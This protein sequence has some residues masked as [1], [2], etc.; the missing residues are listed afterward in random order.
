MKIL[1][2]CAAG[3]TSS[4][5]VANMRKAVQEDPGLDYKIGSC[6]SN[7]TE[8][9]CPQ[10]DVIFIAPQLAYEEELLRKEYSDKKVILIPPVLYGNLDGK[11]VLGL[12]E[13]RE[14]KQ[15]QS[16]FMKL[17]MRMTAVISHSAILQSVSTAMMSLFPV[18]MLGSVFTLLLNF[19]NP[20]YLELVQ[21][22]AL[23]LILNL[24]V[25]M[26]TDMMA[27][28]AL[29]MTAYCYAEK[30]KCSQPGAVLIALVC[31]FLLIHEDNGV[32][33]TDYLGARGMFFSFLVSFL[34]VRFYAVLYRYVK[35]YAPDI[36]QLPENI[37]GSFLTILPML[38][39]IVLV[40]GAYV[41]FHRYVQV[42]FP[43]WFYIN[44]QESV[45]RFVGDHVF[46]AVAMSLIT[47]L[48]WF[49]GI[50]GGQITGTLTNPLTMS[51]SAENLAAWQA[52]QPLPHILNRQFRS[53]YV[54]GG[55]GS[56]LTL[57]FLMAFFAKSSRMKELGRL[58]LPMGIFFINEPILFGLP[59]VLNPLM[60]FPLVFVPSFNMLASWYVTKIGLVPILKGLEIPW[61]TPPVI[62]GIIEGGWRAAL[63][64][65]ILF[66]LNILMW[67]P[68][69]RIQ[70][71]Q[72][73]QDETVQKSATHMAKG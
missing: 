31:Y 32:I 37:L 5:L 28:Y 58:S 18:L 44:V 16:A 25:S 52:G 66:L 22:S 72:Y 46:S 36:D 21:K 14:E 51:L 39:S 41:L 71:M 13:S 62:S 43:E 64:Q 59:L 35:D 15:E 30:K 8:K 45:S 40:L 56:T 19:P 2:I 27:V 7:Q 6:A 60:L 24:G 65:I 69:F 49:F 23:N 4:S 26:T 63:W 47:S 10:A 3:M 17:M 53:I 9:Y 68:F 34:S 73:A 29:M 50:H 42:S 12:L 55:A 38:A 70:D 57:A 61:T 1:V 20:L 11:G 54:F 33:L 67:Y 48:L